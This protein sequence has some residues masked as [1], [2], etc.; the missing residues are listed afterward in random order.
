MA[1]NKLKINPCHFSQTPTMTLSDFDIFSAFSSGIGVASDWGFDGDTAGESKSI[2]LILTTSGFTISF[3]GAVGT[4]A[5][6]P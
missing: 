1:A 4:I 3:G 2:N 6:G 5:G